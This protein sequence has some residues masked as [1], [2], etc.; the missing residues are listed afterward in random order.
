MNARAH[1]LVLSLVLS[2]CAQPQA[3]RYALDPDLVPPALT[4]KLRAQYPRYEVSSASVELAR[5]RAVSFTFELSGSGRVREHVETLPPNAGPR[6]TFEDRNRDG[7][8]DSETCRY[9]GWKAG[10]WTLFDDDFD[11]Y[12]DRQRRHGSFAYDVPARIPVSSP[13]P[14]GPHS[15]PPAGELTEVESLH[16]S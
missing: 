16:G 8:I 3:N 14:P 10:D 13:L 4:E 7:K 5:S 11:G 2:G 15:A 6:F 12:H 9:P 1:L